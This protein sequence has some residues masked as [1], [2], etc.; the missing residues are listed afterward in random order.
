M[1]DIIPNCITHTVM[2]WLAAFWYGVTTMSTLIKSQRLK[3]TLFHDLFAFSY[4]QKTINNEKI[5]RKRA[6][7]EAKKNQ[8][9]DALTRD[10]TQSLI[11]AGSDRQKILALSIGDLAS[12]LKS[13]KLDTVDV[14]QAYQVCCIG[15]CYVR[16]WTK[17]N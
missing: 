1:A 10:G 17:I 7:F 15:S 5:Q 8:L 3:P 4:N 16:F 11:P 14:L 9:T 13:G 2:N 12:G 6:A